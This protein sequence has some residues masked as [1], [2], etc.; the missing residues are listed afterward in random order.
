MGL[1]AI[2]SLAVALAMGPVELVLGGVTVSAE[3]A[4][5]QRERAKGLMGR[6]QLPPNHGMLFVYPD[7]M[8]RSF[9]MKNTALPLSIAFIDATGRV[10]HIADLKPL[11]TTPVSSEVPAMYA[12]EMTQGWF[13]AHGVVIGQPISGLPVP[14]R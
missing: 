7:E 10:V 9:W 11:N 14:A 13:Q 1:M 3:V 6:A 8:V 5:D 12:L 2:L 4:D